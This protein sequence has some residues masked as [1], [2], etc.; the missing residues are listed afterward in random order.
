MKKVWLYKKGIDISE[1][2]HYFLFK[3][4]GTISHLIVYRRD[5]LMA[6]IFDTKLRDYPSF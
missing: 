3:F 5:E 1:I 6:L 4:H 2:K